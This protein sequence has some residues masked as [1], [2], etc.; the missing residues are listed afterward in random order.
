MR[1]CIEPALGNS[2]GVFAV[3]VNG[4]KIESTGCGKIYSVQFCYRHNMWAEGINTIKATAFK[5][6]E[7]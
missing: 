2:N 7:N 1:I 4:C 5:V 3:V 6:S